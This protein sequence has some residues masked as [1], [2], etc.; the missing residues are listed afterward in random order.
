MNRRE[1]LQLSAAAA[2]GATAVPAQSTPTASAV[3]NSVLGPLPVSQLGV[4]LPHEHVLVDFI[5]ADRVSRS[6]Y[7][8]DE[9]FSVA[10]PHL[11]KLKESGCQ[12]LFE[13][14]PAFIGRD[15][16]LLERLAKAVGIQLITNTGYYG[17]ANDK[18]VPAHAYQ[19]SAEQL[20]ARWL[21]EWRDGIE[22]SGIKPG[23]IK[24]G[25]DNGPL[26]DIDRKLV[27]AAALTHLETGLTIAS[28]T[29]NSAAALEQVR[30][31]REAGV[32]AAAW[33]WVHAKREA[34]SE[35]LFE[36]T[37]QGGWVEFDNV[38]P[39]KADVCVDLLSLMKERGHLGRVLISQDAGWYHV[40]EP[41]GGNFRPF[42]YLFT[43][44][45][46]RLRE[47]G[48]TDAE[49]QSLAQTNPA[50]AFSPTVRRR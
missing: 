49:I 44:F 25:V 18:Y 47:R 46:P 33:I 6:R 1:F 50:R 48:F 21:R 5:G 9:A 19:E 24:I 22:D 37:G 4:T 29:G 38:S 43:A 40:G 16:R 2:A 14:T 42:D 8:A 39:E 20:C 3:I 36:V 13:C 15:P 27:R 34:G 28:H 35:A 10:L 23:F 11:Q 31:L 26:S 7:S 30:I 32:S 12:T 17:A 45:L 41:G